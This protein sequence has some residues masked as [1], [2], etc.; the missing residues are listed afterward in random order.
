MNPDFTLC[1]TGVVWM[2]AALAKAQEF[3]EAWGGARWISD[4][5]ARR[6]SPRF[7]VFAGS[8]GPRV[9]PTRVPHA[10]IMYPGNSTADLA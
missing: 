4:D 5:E 10:G 7:Q 8:P 3:L 1:V 6:D 9:L 2:V